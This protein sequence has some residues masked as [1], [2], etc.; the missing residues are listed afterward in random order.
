MLHARLWGVVLNKL[1]LAQHIYRS[2]ATPQTYVPRHRIRPVW[3]RQWQALAS[4]VHLIYPSCF[5][6]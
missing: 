3:P 2:T 4:V 5:H 6:K 1:A